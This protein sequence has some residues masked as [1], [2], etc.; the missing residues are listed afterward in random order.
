MLRHGMLEV[1]KERLN[2]LLHTDQD[3]IVRYWQ[4][5]WPKLTELEQEHMERWRAER[6]D[7]EQ[8][9]GEAQILE[10]A[11][12]PEAPPELRRSLLAGM[13][14]GM[15]EATEALVKRFRGK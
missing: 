14:A 3:A 2:E 7:E 12:P 13:Y 11:F 6:A 15:Q 4:E 5:Q 1:I 9:A 8:R 10:H